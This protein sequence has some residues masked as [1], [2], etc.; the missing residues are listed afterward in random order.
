MFVFDTINSMKNKSFSLKLPK[1]RDLSIHL[2]LFIL[3]FFGVIMMVSASMSTNVVYIDLVM[4]AVKQVV[5][6]TLGYLGYIL[7]AKF[8]PIQALRK[9]M[10]PIM[11]L[12]IIFLLIPLFGKARFGAM[13]WIDLPGGISIQPSEFIKLVVIWV[14]VIYLGGVRLRQKEFWD[15]VQTPMLYLGVVVFIIGYFQSDLGSSVV[16]LGI[17]V[18]TYLLAGHRKLLK[19]Q[20]WIVLILVLGFIAL[21]F[22]LSQG[23]LEWLEKMGLSGYMLNRFKVAINPFYDIYGSGYQLVNGLVAMVRGN[24]FGVGYGNGLQKYGYLPA[25]KTDYILAVIGEELGYVGILFV[26]SLYFILMFRLLLHTYKAQSEKNKMIL[27]GVLMYMALHFI[28]NV[29]GVSG[30]IPLTGVPLLLLSAGG[31]STLAIL[32]AFGMAQHAII[33]EYKK[34][35]T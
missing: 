28:L 18:S 5:F 26:F 7:F 19:S 8:L 29:G 22:I 13:A 23:G 4:Q 25:A 35:H 31:S 1:G 32:I 9:L 6:I 15:L 20:L 16:V 11:I 33:D 17:G 27:F 14:N 12:S 30:L 34:D 24:L 2:S 3:A 21:P 10:I